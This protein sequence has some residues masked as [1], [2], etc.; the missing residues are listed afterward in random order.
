MVPRLPAAWQLALAVAL[1]AAWELVEN[2]GFVIERYRATAALGYSGD[3]IVNSL[4][5]ITVCGLGVALARLLGVRRAAVL[6]AVVEVT[7]L[8]W[9]RDSLLLNVLTLLYP[10]ALV[11]GWQLG[12]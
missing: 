1:E 6:F 2:S 11:R 8:V 9:I 3:T 4:G 10:N 12:R 5:D 7:L